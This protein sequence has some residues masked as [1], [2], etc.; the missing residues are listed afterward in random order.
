[1]TCK[2]V[3]IDGPADA[4]AIIREGHRAAVLAHPDWH[5]VAASQDPVLQLAWMVRERLLSYDELDDLL[6]LDEEASE[7]DRIVEEAFAELGRE[8]TLIRCS[9]LDQLR[10]DGLITPAQQ[11]AAMAGSMNE[12]YDSAASLLFSMILDGVMTPDEFYA[13]HAELIAKQDPDSHSQRCETVRAAFGLL[14]EHEA[15]REALDLDGARLKKQRD[16][17]FACGCMC[18]AAA[19]WWLLQR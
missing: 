6:T 16:V 2:S 15:R 19:C 3:D 5:A 1:M 8:V 10:C 11:A 14:K 13:M 12:P 7:S 18:T 4:L 17:L 9:L